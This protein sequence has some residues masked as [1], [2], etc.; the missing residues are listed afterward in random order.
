[1]LNSLR[2]RNFSYPYLL[3]KLLKRPFSTTSIRK[4]DPTL[5]TII[6]AGTPW[7]PFLVLSNPIG[8]TLIVLVSMA[9]ALF[10][11][12]QPMP[13]I[14]MEIPF[15]EVL[16]LLSS[17]YHT[18]IE[19]ES[20]TTTFIVNNISMFSQEQLRN[21]Y[22]ILQEIVNIEEEIYYLLQHLIDIL[23]EDSMER[24]VDILIDLSQD[25]TFEGDNLMDLIRNLEDRLN[26]PHSERMPFINA[27]EA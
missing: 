13:N 16:Q 9:T 14:Y 20:L 8:I 19:L 17:I 18:Y 22:L 2:I 12:T 21:L 6:S 5:F 7:D 1:M 26:I 23:E 27:F 4:S 24:E 10:Y 3:P 25:F 11:V 15:P